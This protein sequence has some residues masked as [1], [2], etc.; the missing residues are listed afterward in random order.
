MKKCKTCCQ[1]LPLDQFYAKRKECK[2]CIS[3]H[4]HAT[5]GLLKGR[6]TYEPK[7]LPLEHTCRVCNLTLPITEFYIG[8]PAQGRKSPKI[9]NRCKPCTRLYYQKNRE[10]ILEKARAKAPP[11]K[12]R[13]PLKTQEET[14]ARIAAYK[15]RYRK[16]N[17]LFYLRSHIGTSIANALSHE[18]HVKRKS[19]VEIIGCTIDQLRL[20][21]EKQFLPGMSWLNRHL[22]HIDHIVPQKL[23]TTEEQVY[24]LNHYTNLRPLWSLDNQLKA[25]SITEDVKNH[26]LYTKLYTP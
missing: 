9:E 25:A 1:T 8:S 16:E 3:A 24:Q 6:P 2:S 22:W 7:Q 17:K 5:K 21:L 20:H 23:A 11:P 10:T 12:P 13:P 18:G 26:P 4:Y 14:R 19:T 15:R